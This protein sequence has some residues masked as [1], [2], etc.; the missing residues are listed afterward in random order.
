[1]LNSK[2]LSIL[3]AS[4]VVGTSLFLGCSKKNS[5][6]SLHTAKGGKKIGGRYTLNEIRGNPASLDPVRMN[7]KLEDD[8]AMNIFD[9][10]ID[11]NENLELVPELASKWEISPDG[12]SYTFHLRNDVYF[13]D[14]ACFP[15]GKGR[16]MVASDV[17]YSF[18]RVCDPKTTTS[19]FWVFQDIVEGANTYFNRKADEVKEVTGFI[20]QDDSTFTVRLLK[21]FAPFLEHLTTSFGYVVPHEAVEKYGKDFFRHPIG[22]GAFLF[23][24][25]S[26]DQEILL[27]KNPNYWQYDN[28]GNRLPLLNEVRFT[29]I[30]DDKTLFANF[31]RGA[32]DEDFTIPTELFPNVITADKK[33]TSAYEKKYTLQ[34]IPAMNSYFFDILCTDKLFSNMALRRALSFAVDRNQICKYVLKNAPHGPAD[35]GIVPPSF[36][37]YPIDSVHGITFNPD[38]AKHWLEVAGYPDGKNLPTIT[39]SVYNEPRPMQIAEA[40]QHMWQENLGAKV[41][42]HVMQASQLLDASEDGTLQLWLTRW[43]ADYPEIE[44]FLNLFS[45]SLV[46]SDPKQ[47]SYPNSTR[48]KNTQYTQIFEQAIGTT[49]EAQRLQLYARAE[50]IAAFEAPSIPLFYEEHYRLLQPYVR[51]NPLDPMNRIDLK[52]VWLDK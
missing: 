15:S 27:K 5:D 50:N 25:W 28:A 36:T 7:S 3:F 35:H 12:K 29:F 21:P 22:T 41:D 43:Y 39:I 51:D 13:H 32:V 16:K 45:G 34:H 33:L 10:L 9:K 19:G 17:K 20:A 44:N 8:I 47:K 6:P 11:N 52:Y 48:W 49:D 23:D 46:P 2:R 24:H 14:D 30:K 42:I 37:R 26:E 4:L 38:S 40:V 31:E 18:Q 1:M